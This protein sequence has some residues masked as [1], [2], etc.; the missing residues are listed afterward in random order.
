M[1]VMGATFQSVH[2]HRKVLFFHGTKKPEHRCRGVE[3][4]APVS[5]LLSVLPSFIL[6]GHKIDASLLGPH[7][8][9]KKEEWERAEDTCQLSMT[10]HQ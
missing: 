6:F 2:R 1:E 10:L 9:S 8:H 5:L 4:A 7:P 3:G